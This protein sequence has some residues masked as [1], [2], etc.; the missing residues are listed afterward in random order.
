[1]MIVS[2]GKKLKKVNA[3]DDFVIN[4]RI[5]SRLSS[6]RTLHSSRSDEKKVL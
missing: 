1:M 4:Y 5:V 2:E 6:S 3:D